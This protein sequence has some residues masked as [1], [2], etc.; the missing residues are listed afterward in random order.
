MN[1]VFLKEIS[2]NEIKTLK[3]FLD[4]LKLAKEHTA[5]KPSTIQDYLTYRNKI[6]KYL[7]YP[8]SKK[9]K[10][11]I[12]ASDKTVK[13]H[14][15]HTKNKSPNYKSFNT[16]YKPF[17][18]LFLSKGN[19]DELYKMAT[20]IDKIS[21]SIKKANR[22][23]EELISKSNPFEISSLTLFFSG[24]KKTGLLSQFTPDDMDDLLKIDLNDFKYTY[25]KLPDHDDYQYL[26]YF[27]QNLKNSNKPIE[28]S[29]IQQ[30]YIADFKYASKS[31]YKEL[32]KLVDNYLF[33]NDKSII[34]D[35]LNRMKEFPE[36]IKINEAAKLKI[37]EVYRGIQEQEEYGSNVQKYI[38]EDKRQKFIATS[39]TISAAK[40]FAQ[41]KGHLDS[42]ANSNAGVI[43]TYKVD[44]HS[45][46]LDTSIFG[47]AFGESEIL[48][49][50]TK[51]SIKDSEFESYR[52]W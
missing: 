24:G 15:S 44:R 50:A 29:A 34:Q 38:N 40:N 42:V 25:L 16:Q 28:V 41:A 33:N 11:M 35:I 22:N 18:D 12:D 8:F 45:I 39:D 36:L 4:M 27:I 2:P 30:K 49:D 32:D 52:D 9:L 20:S 14:Q 47:S 17:K 7:V 3:A 10:M 23:E 46:V 5:S 48:I 31:T 51:A 6:E 26:V 13:E 1:T 37:K 43:I 21:S 19:I